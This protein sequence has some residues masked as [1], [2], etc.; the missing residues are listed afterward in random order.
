MHNSHPEYTVNTISRKEFRSRVAQL[1]GKRQARG[2]TFKAPYY[3]VEYLNSP[4]GLIIFAHH[5][6]VEGQ[7]DGI[8]PAGVS[9]SI[10]R[11]VNIIE[12][13][14]ADAG[15]LHS[16]NVHYMTRRSQGPLILKAF[17]RM[18][19]QGE[20]EAP[21]LKTNGRFSLEIINTPAGPI[22]GVTEYGGDVVHV[23][24]PAEYVSEDREAA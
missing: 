23:I 16:Y 13:L 3:S 11:P 4:V 12:P 5:D 6:T 18:I 24:E 19:H 9:E 15:G 17:G 20:P 21:S 22:V 8:H 2:L 10:N 7:I 1:V 14:D